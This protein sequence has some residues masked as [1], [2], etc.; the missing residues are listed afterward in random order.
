MFKKEQL[1]G[2]KAKAAEHILQ[3]LQKSF[4]TIAFV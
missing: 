3:T 4:A 2:L 1:E